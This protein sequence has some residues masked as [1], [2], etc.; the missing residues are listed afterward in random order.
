MSDR[1]TASLVPETCEYRIMEFGIGDLVLVGLMVYLCICLIR[2][3]MRVE[4]YH[5]TRLGP[6]ASL[7]DECLRSREL[8]PVVVFVLGRGVSRFRMLGTAA[9]VGA[10]NHSVILAES[11]H[12]CLEPDAAN[13]LHAYGGFRNRHAVLVGVHGGGMAIARILEERR[14]SLPILRTGFVA[15][16]ESKW[17]WTPD[18]ASRRAVEA[19][20]RELRAVREQAADGKGQRG[21]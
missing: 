21:E 20:D 19:I 5:A 11:A 4:E 18:C 16:P 3:C 6:E 17:C 8:P 2:R 1:S 7:A 12:A 14:R 13:V 15:M 9:M 10:M